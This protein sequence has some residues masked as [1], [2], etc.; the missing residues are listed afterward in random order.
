MCIRDRSDEFLDFYSQIL[1]IY[2]VINIYVPFELFI[3][4]LKLSFSFLKVYN[5]KV[6]SLQ[7]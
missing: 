3:N 2:N 1:K 5:F 6:L 4:N 7:F